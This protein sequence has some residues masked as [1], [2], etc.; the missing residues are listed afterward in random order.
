MVP[1]L[2]NYV[3]MQSALNELHLYRL[4]DMVKRFIEIN[5]DNILLSVFVVDF[6]SLEY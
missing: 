2:N 4:L 3:V 6:P 5:S 1:V